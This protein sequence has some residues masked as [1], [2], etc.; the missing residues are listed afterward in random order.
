LIALGKTN[1]KEKFAG[2]WQS[3]GRYISERYIEERKHI[4]ITYRLS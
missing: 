4:L 3:Y 2:L 1:V